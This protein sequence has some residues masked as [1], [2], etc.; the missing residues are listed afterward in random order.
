VVE[1]WTSTVLVPPGWTA[2]T[3]GIG[4]LVLERA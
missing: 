2:V 1:E 4:D 3:D